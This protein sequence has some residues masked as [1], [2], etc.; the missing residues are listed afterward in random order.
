MY[1]IM[2]SYDCFKVLLRD[3]LELCNCVQN[4]ILIIFK[5]LHF[6]DYPILAPIF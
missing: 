6:S 5:C 4:M 2:F 3:R 1:E